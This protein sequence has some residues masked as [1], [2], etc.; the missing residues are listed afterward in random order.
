MKE[1]Y[2]SW[3]GASAGGT[4]DRSCNDD[5]QSRRA[6]ETARRSLP[7]SGFSLPWLTAAQPEVRVTRSGSGPTS[8]RLTRSPGAG[9]TQAARLLSLSP[10]GL[11]IQ[12]QAGCN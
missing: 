4:S 9:V 2:D 11:P 10:A 3:R 12:C 8:M 7:V 1:S 5:H 6:R